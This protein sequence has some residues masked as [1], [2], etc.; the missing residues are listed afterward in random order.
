MS[1]IHNYVTFKD[2][3]T[4]TARDKNGQI[5]GI[6]VGEDLITNTGMAAVAGLILKDITTISGFEY[7]AIGSD[8]TAAAAGQTVLLGEET[9]AAATGTRVTTTQT[10]DT[11]QLVYIF[12]SGKPAGLN[13][14]STGTQAI[15]ESGVFNSPTAG[16]LQM[17]CR[18]TF[19]ALNIDWDGGDSLQITWKVQVS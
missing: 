16:N 10:D 17:L 11:A 6:H 9:R 1:D 5:I 14:T 12:A 4:A 8:S 13:G 19:G 3:M 15:D 2:W 18:Q 7:I